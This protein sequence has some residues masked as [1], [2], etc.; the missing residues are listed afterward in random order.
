MHRLIQKCFSAFSIK[1]RLFFF[2]LFGHFEISCSFVA[3][4]LIFQDF[5]GVYCHLV[6]LKKIASCIVWN[7]SLD[8][9][10]VR[11]LTQYSTVSLLGPYL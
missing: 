4:K 11:L 5:L 6:A 1:N 2:F 8:S 10:Y 7:L 9:F 3:R